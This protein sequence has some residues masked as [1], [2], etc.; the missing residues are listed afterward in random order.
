MI[1]SDFFTSALVIWAL[2]AWSLWISGMSF[3]LRKN[4]DSLPAIFGVLSGARFYPE[5]FRKGYLLLIG[6]FW[7]GVGLSTCVGQL[8]AVT[9]GF[10]GA[11]RYTISFLTLAS[12][13][14]LLESLFTRQGIIFFPIILK[15]FRGS[16]VK[17]IRA[18]FVVGS[19]FQLWAAFSRA[20]AS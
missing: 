2:E 20:G 19:F 13:W 10:H 4:A 12:F 17:F 8:V 6:S 5:R 16:H 7:F 15:L 14:N 11:E 3:R 18:F 9:T 1:S